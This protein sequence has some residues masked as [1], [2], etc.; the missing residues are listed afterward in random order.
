MKKAPLYS[1]SRR[2][3]AADLVPPP[4]PTGAPAAAPQQAPVPRSR[5]R[6]FAS[7]HERA[8]WVAALLVLVLAALLWRAAG[9]KPPSRVGR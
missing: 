7:R 1:R 5:L 2:G 9:P 8:L 4:E 6:A 3:V